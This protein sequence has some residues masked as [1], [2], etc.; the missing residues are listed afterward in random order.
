MRRGPLGTGGHG[1]ELVGRAPD[2]VGEHVEA[3][4]AV[5]IG[6]QAER[7]LAGR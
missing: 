5:A 6:A 2:A 3:G 7:Q 4:Y 1:Q